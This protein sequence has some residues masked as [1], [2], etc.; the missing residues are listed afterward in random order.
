MADGTPAVRAPSTDRARGQVER[1][2]LRRGLPHLIDGYSA[3]RDVLT[4]AAP[5]LALVFLV[6]V[7]G[8]PK[9]SFPVWLDAVAV[10]AGFAILLGAWA[11]V[12]RLRGRRPLALPTDVGRTEV[13]VFVLVPPLLPLVFGAQVGS[14]VVTMLANAVLLGVVYLGASYGVV[15]TTRWAAGRL[16]RQAADVFAL[17][18]RTLPLLALFVTFLFL[19]AEVWQS[20]GTVHGFTYAL[21]LGLVFTVGTVFLVMRTPRDVAELGVFESWAE[22]RRLAEGTPAEPLIDPAAGSDRAPVAGLPGLSRRQWGNVGLVLIVS[23]GLQILTVSLLIG[24][25]FLLLGV[26]TVSEATTQAWSGSAHVLA[27][28]HLDGRDLVLT[29]QLLRVAGFLTAFAGLNFTVYL[30]TDPT[31]R[32]EFR[33]EVVGEVRQALAVR[34]VY[35]AAL[36][37]AAGSPGSAESEGSTEREGSAG[38]AG[39]APPS[40]GSI[41]T[42][43][44]DRVPPVV[45]DPS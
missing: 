42:D 11:L 23:Q 1:W 39:S 20:A 10:A 19:T 12:N 32:A 27:S 8:A 45:E 33:E 24:G 14:A 9:R 43:T 15:P 28:V 4:R 2:F 5:V 13:A 7:L 21:L 35:L 31:Y 34:A 26:L 16:A 38:S 18:V 30:V 3:S 41:R 29:E 36:G 25:F 40:A 6:E 44:D 22:V 17:L 37:G